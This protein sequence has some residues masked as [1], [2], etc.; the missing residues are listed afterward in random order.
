METLVLFTGAAFDEQ[1]GGFLFS[2]G[3][4]FLHPIKNNENKNI[5]RAANRTNFFI[6]QIFF[7]F[8]Q[9]FL[10]NCKFAQKIFQKKT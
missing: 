7:K 5:N 3:G 4:F 1:V 8:L 2:T 6:K 9:L 10:Q